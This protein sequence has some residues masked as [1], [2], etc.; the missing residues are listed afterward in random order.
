MK[1]NRMCKKVVGLACAFAVFSCMAIENTPIKITTDF[2][3]RSAYQSRMRVSED[4]P[5]GVMDL[6]IT[7]DAKKFG[8]FGVKHW[9]YSALCNRNTYKHRRAFNE[10]DFS[11]FWRRDIELF[12]DFT[13]SNQFMNWWITIP[14]NIEPYKGKQNNSSYEL[15]YVGALKNPYLIPSI[16]I[17]RGWIHASWV[18]FQY[19]VSKPFELCDLG[20]AESPS[21]VTVT[22]GFFVE[23]G[24]SGLFESR[25][26]KKESGSYHSGIGSC[27]A[28]VSLD[29]KVAEWF[30]MYAMLQQF[31]L[32]SSD[33]RAGVHGNQHRDYTMFRIG[34]KF[35]F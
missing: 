16:L 1:E 21:P 25:F 33:A 23:T 20:N 10:V 8:T 22:P 35:T 32:V 9:N 4:R 29:W 14:N 30:S 19:G 6:T 24:D 27:I 17:R 26:G 5:V 15:W 2:S 28:Q 13:L 18:Y 11:A 12:E 31:G 34:M 3:I 7:A